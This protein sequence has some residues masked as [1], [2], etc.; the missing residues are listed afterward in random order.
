VAR[1][2]PQ[3][4]E[5]GIRL[6]S[7]VSVDLLAV[8]ADGDRIIQVLINLLGNALRY[9]PGGIGLTIAKAIVEAHDGQIWATSPG[10]NQGTTFSLTLPIGS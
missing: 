10:P 3:F 8:Q 1:I 6:T 5:K 7:D 2:A 4:A 9:T